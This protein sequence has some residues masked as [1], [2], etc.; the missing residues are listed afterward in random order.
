MAKTFEEYGV[1]LVLSGHDHIYARSHLLYQNNPTE[2]HTKGI[3]YI[4]GGS[5]GNK[6]YPVKETAKNIML[7]M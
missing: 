7:N 6:F 4:I 5:G 3:T 1:D 2:D